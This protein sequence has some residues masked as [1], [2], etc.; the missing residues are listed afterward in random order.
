MLLGYAELVTKQDAE[1]L[2]YLIDST[3]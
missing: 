2:Q 1:T 3:I